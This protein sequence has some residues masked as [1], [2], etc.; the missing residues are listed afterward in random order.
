M[1]ELRDAVR[2]HLGEPCPE[3]RLCV[4]GLVG[5]VIR[6]V[7]DGTPVR[8][9]VER[10]ADGRTRVEVTDPDPRVLPVLLDAAPDDESGRGLMLLDAVTLRWGVVQGSASKTVWCEV[11]EA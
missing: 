11:G 8:V 1:A 7:G 2:A 10:G 4:S 9:R 6:H 3:V 5:N